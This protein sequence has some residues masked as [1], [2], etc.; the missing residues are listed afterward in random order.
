V[1]LTHSMRATYV[2][3]ASYLCVSHIL[4]MC[5]FMCRIYFYG[6]HQHPY[7]RHI[8][9]ITKID[10]ECK[11]HV[12]LCLYIVFIC[13]HAKHMYMCVDVSYLYVLYMC[14][15]YV[16][17]IFFDVSYMCVFFFLICLICLFYICPPYIQR[18]NKAHMHVT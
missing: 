6:G 16:P 11:T 9:T 18:I 14:S 12:Y 8:N 10:T 3:C 15:T 4:F 2:K 13:T 5:L 1:W 17:H 7:I